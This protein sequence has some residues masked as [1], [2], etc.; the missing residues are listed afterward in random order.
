MLGLFGQRG[1]SP[2]AAGDSAALLASALTAVSP[3][4]RT[5]LTTM[6]GVLRVLSESGLEPHQQRLMGAALRAGSRL[7]AWVD[8]MADY[9]A[10]LDGDAN[11]VAYPVDVAATLETARDLAG[12]EDIHGATEISVDVDPELHSA[13]VGDGRRLQQAAF[14]M[15]DAVAH[16][17]VGGAVRVRARLRGDDRVTLTVRHSP[18]VWDPERLQTAL[19]ILSDGRSE[20]AAARR[21]SGAALALV[22]AQ[23]IA[24][25]MGGT[26]EARRD[27]DANL[28][29]EFAVP[30]APAPVEAAATSPDMGPLVLVVE[31]NPVNQRLIQVQ[32]QSIGCGAHVV[33]SAEEALEAVLEDDFDI[34]LMDLH[35]PGLDGFSATIQLRERGGDGAAI[36]V[37]ALTADV[38]HDVRR[39]AAEAGM[40][41]FVKKPIDVSELADVI[42]RFAVSS[43]P[44]FANA[45]PQATPEM[46]A[47][48]APHAAPPTTDIAA[49]EPAQAE[50]AS[51]AATSPS[52]PVRE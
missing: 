51:P 28:I 44:D 7:E 42:R 4:I 22:V 52:G 21:D 39:R 2:A 15:M 8:N 49:A 29:L 13:R 47:P 40:Q 11:L 26:L 38:A 35:L 31:D 24:G 14:N 37:V 12:F 17:V 18:G 25:W 32:L 23:R 48:S 41:A 27:G 3:E 5:P 20:G 46:S 36:P 16:S 50:P 43:T 6:L 30:M 10:P 19:R 45:P 34:I 1:K 9:I 33:S